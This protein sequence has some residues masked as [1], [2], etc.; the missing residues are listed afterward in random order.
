MYSSKPTKVYSSTRAA[1]LHGYCV[2][3]A[4]V[5]NIVLE[6]T[7]SYL[8]VCEIPDSNRASKRGVVP[9][10]QLSL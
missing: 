9:R 5:I 1:Y 8:Q 6:L 10:M 4:L 7:Y 2:K 3:A